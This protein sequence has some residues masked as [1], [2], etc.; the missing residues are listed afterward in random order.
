MVAL[1]LPGKISAKQKPFESAVQEET[2]A[3]ARDAGD[4]PH[5]H[6]IRQ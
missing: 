6:L 1:P 4:V 2:G 5:K 3:L